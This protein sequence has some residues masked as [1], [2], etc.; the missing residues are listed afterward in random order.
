MPNNKKST[1]PPEHN[2]KDDLPAQISSLMERLRI[3]KKQLGEMT[4]LPLKSLSQNPLKDEAHDRLE[5]VVH[6]F[7][8]VEPWTGSAD[9]ALAWYRSTPIPSF[10]RRTAE[11]LVKSGYADAVI[12]N[13]Q[14]TALGGYA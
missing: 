2:D 6:I 12:I 3:D 13:L 8:Y 4:G 11:E 7:D 14:R 9:Q 1:S 10:G 5:K